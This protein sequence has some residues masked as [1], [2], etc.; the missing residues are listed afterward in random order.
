MLGAFKAKFHRQSRIRFE[1]IELLQTCVDDLVSVVE[2]KT[3]VKVTRD[4]GQKTCVHCLWFMG[5]WS[6]KKGTMAL[7]INIRLSGLR[8]LGMPKNVLVTTVKNC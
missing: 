4:F 7:C 3:G 6:R 5:N 1:L 2:W 8:V